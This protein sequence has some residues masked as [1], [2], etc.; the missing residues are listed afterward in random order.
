MAKKHLVR[1]EREP[2]FGLPL[3]DHP[4]WGN[5]ADCRKIFL[6]ETHERDPR[7]RIVY[8]LLPDEATPE[9]ADVIIIGSR[10]DDEVYVEV[11]Q[12]LGRPLGP[13]HP[14]LG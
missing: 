6:D 7:W 9:I 5:L 11:M 8:R 10:E 1:L 3:A 14:S 13:L 2:D 4:L 12:R